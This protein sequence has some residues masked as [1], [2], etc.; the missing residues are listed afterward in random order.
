MNDKVH[1]KEQLANSIVVTSPNAGPRQTP[2]GAKPGFFSGMQAGVPFVGEAPDNA[3]L[4]SYRMGHNLTE[5]IIAGLGIGKA[6]TMIPAAVNTTNKGIKIANSIIQGISKSY[7]TGKIRFGAAEGAM[8]LGSGAA[9]HWATQEFPDSGVALFVAEMG[10]GMIVDAVPGTLKL[11]ARHG[12]AGYLARTAANTKIGQAAITKFTDFRRGVDPSYAGGRARER[13][14][15]QGIT[16]KEAGNI[17]DEVDSLRG[18][19]SLLPGAADEM[20]FAMLSGNK[21]LLQLEKDVMNAATEDA[22]S[23]QTTKRLQQ[24]NDMITKGFEFNPDDPQSLATHMSSMQAYYRGLLDASLTAAAKDTDDRLRRFAVTA[25]KEEQANLIA[26]SALDNSMKSAKATEK[27]LWQAIPNDVLVP[28]DGFA[29]AWMKIRGEMT[30]VS[31]GSDTP[32]NAEA[33]LTSINFGKNK[34]Q[35]RIGEWISVQEGRDLIG[36]L[37]EEARN[38]TS[39]LGET[40]WNKARL[41]NELADAIN[42]D[43][44]ASIDGLDPA[45]REQMNEAVAFTKEFSATWRNPAISG[46]FARSDTGSRLVRDTEVLEHLFSNPSKNRGNYDDLIAAVGDDPAVNGALKD[47]LRFSMFNN[48]SFNREAAESFLKDNERLLDRMPDFRKEI[49]DAISINDDGMNILKS[50]EADFE[51]ILAAATV[52]LKDQ[53]LAAITKVFKSDNPTRNMAEII[54]L[55]RQDS[56]GAAM[57][58]VQE[59]FGTYMLEQA[60]KGSDF[61]TT[62]GSRYVDYNL[63]EETL[64]K[65]A[66]RDTLSMVFDEK[67]LLRWNKVRATARRVQM[68][69]DTGGSVEK[70]QQDLAS[71]IL[72][73]ASRVAGARLGGGVIASN[74]L[75]SSLQTAAIISS[76]LSEMAKAGI[77]NPSQELIKMAVLDENLFKALY[78]NLENK[79]EKA[80]EALSLLQRAGQWAISKASRGAGQRTSSAETLLVEPMMTEEQQQ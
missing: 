36:K 15:R 9:G 23:I 59:A 72:V 76:T 63:L 1:P 68:F 17:L 60:T 66:I 8:G 21:A 58:G 20:G 48:Q 57:L 28:T 5:S 55:A 50:T 70:I 13:L 31:R 33:W 52:F 6:S 25:G 75:G 41:A 35:P 10:G 78:S 38:A 18:S 61:V 73:T 54:G 56:T 22:L 37:R 74:T 4:M 53:P 65:P 40:N 69:T 39:A 62:G 27:Q 24:L 51:P 47:Y 45:I 42:L 80:A 14:E 79:P 30:Q 26:R 46:L 3:S 29:Q 67:Q 2:A 49:E 71:K 12:P 19:D 32:W 64:R 43:M 11:A 77:E 34:G 44:G 16:E 7:K